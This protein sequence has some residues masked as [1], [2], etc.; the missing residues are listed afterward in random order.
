MIWLSLSTFLVSLW[1]LSRSL[2]HS[3]VR[4]FRLMF[5]QFF[6]QN[7][8]CDV[9]FALKVAGYLWLATNLTRFASREFE[10]IFD[11]HDLLSARSASQ[12][13]SLVED[14]FLELKQDREDLG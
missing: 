2:A 1:L 3:S 14:L 6:R 7:R 13:Q 10:E 11:F 4:L 12:Y 9:L 5:L 8:F